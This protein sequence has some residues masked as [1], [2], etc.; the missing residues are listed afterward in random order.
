MKTAYFDEMIQIGL[1]NLMPTKTVNFH[2]ND[3]PWMTGHLQLLIRQRPKPL[4][5]KN[6]HP[7]LFYRNRVNR[8]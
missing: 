4:N 8:E 2:S 5:E 6:A 1:N 7:F 3:A